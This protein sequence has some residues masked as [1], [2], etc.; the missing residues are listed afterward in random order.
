MELQVHVE[1]LMQQDILD[2]AANQDCCKLLVEFIQKGNDDY[3]VVLSPA[4]YTAG[5][6]EAVQSFIDTFAE[7]IL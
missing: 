7:Y 5:Y 6:G 2:W 4:E 3:L 1:S